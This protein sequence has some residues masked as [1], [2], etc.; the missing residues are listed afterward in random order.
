MTPIE[1]NIIVV[2]EKGNEYEAT[3]P[4]RAKGLVKAGRARFIDANK[5][6]L[7]CPP[8]I[9]L[10]DNNMTENTNNVKNES[11]YSIEFILN[12]IAK[13]QEQTEY[14]NTTLEKLSELG[15]DVDFLLNYLVPMSEGAIEYENGEREVGDPSLVWEIRDGKVK[16][17]NAKIVI[18]GADRDA[19]VYYGYTLVANVL[20]ASWKRLF[21]VDI[22]VE[23]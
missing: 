3:Y 6:C 16:N 20:E 5:I 17:P 11:I 15:E 4:K 2:D 10:E 8:D 7:T 19:L 12:Q 1:K 18:F 23:A 21:N 9:Y 13:L 22:V 14:L